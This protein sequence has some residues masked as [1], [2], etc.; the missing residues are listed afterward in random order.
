MLAV[1]ILMGFVRPALS[2]EAR[3]LDD[4]ELC[5]VDQPLPEVRETLLQGVLVRSLVILLTPREVRIVRDH[6]PW[7]VKR[8]PL[9][10]RQSSHPLAVVSKVTEFKL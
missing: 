8:V 6:R 7:I 1:F 10:Y 4:M 3:D 9:Y 2:N 5:Q